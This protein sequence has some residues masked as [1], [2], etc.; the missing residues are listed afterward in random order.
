MRGPAIPRGARGL[1]DSP[2]WFNVGTWRG[3]DL[4]L[5]PDPRWIDRFSC[6][7]TVRAIVATARGDPLK[8]I[9]VLLAGM[10][11]L[12]LDIL[13]HVVA[14]QPDMT[15][16]GTVDDDLLGAAQRARADVL[17]VGQDVQGE[18]DFYRALL[19]RH[20]QL[21]VL[22]L[23]DDGKSGWLYDLR[24]RRVRLREISAR[25]LARAIRGQ[26][27][28]TSRTGTKARNSTRRGGL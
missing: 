15:I 4:H 1:R 19:L 3:E 16:V 22:T 10:P 18:R 5:H 21:R 23:A 12:M 26:A 13:H 28:S 2:R 14:A 20:P 25:S 7:N 17:V 24:P 11:T 8:R 9:R 27:L 6:R